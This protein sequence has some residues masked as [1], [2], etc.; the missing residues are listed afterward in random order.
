MNEYQIYKNIDIT[1]TLFKKN[2]YLEE[3]WTL[4]RIVEYV[5]P[6]I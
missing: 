5:G 6:Q 4:L 2:N 1:D 3:I